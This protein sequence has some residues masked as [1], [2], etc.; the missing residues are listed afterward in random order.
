MEMDEQNNTK[1]DSK[2][3]VLAAHS[4]NHLLQKFFNDEAIEP[5]LNKFISFSDSEEESPQRNDDFLKPH[6]V[7]TRTD[8]ELERMREE[9]RA[10][11][12]NGLHA[13]LYATRQFSFNEKYYKPN[14]TADI[15]KLITK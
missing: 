1:D 8:E 5:P 7:K 11:R 4:K 2:E 13:P 6:N 12:E 9:R 10:K 3:Q 15:D 14:Q